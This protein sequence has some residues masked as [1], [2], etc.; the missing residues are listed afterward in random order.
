MLKYVLLLVQLRLNLA[1]FSKGKDSI[2]DGEL[3]KELF[4]CLEWDVAHSASRNLKLER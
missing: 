2:F 3:P 1:V 4:L